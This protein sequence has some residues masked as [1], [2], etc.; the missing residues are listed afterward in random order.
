MTVMTATLERPLD[1]PRV[2]AHD[3]PSVA[4]LAPPHRRSRA[5]RR[6]VLLALAVLVAATT[7]SYVG[8]LRAPGSGSV[9]ERSVEWVR[10]H[11][12][13][14]IVNRVEQW[15]Y[16]RKAPGDGTPTAAHLPAVP[17]PVDARGATVVEPVGR[18]APGPIASFAPDP[19]P[20]EGVWTPAIQQVGSTPVMYTTFV[21]PDPANTK[22]VAAI[23]RF[24]QR[25]VRT[26]AVPGTREPGGA[27]WAWQSQIPTSARV[28]LVAAFNSGFRFKHIDGGYYTEGRTSV[29]LVDGDA[30]LVIDDSGRVDIGTWGTDVSM[31]PTTATVRQN[32]H[33]I[34]ADGRP[35][36]G[37]QHNAD[38]RW[39]SPRH[40]LQIT[41]RSGVGVTADG[42]LVVVAG[43]HLTLTA[44]ANA[45]TSAGAV[46]GMQLDIHTR[47]VTVNL[48]QPVAGTATAVTATEL[49]PD[50]PTSP[51]RFL[52]V[53][54]RD[55]FA[56][57]VR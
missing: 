49:L 13:D 50:M 3:V 5:V 18:P 36:P 57:F 41:W 27:A 51:T 34:V 52:G 55:F 32:L 30:S 4:P 9:G 42:D 35:V 15:Y 14:G 16:T 39:G 26:V 28:G 7:V 22:V 54:H 43:D 2:A 31:T 6:L 21:R 8:Y 38:G 25:L 17:A 46:R 47:Q 33:L 10:D 48:F 40:Q 44:L 29:P 1:D 37:L 56:V 12:G 20:G 53:D 24:D 23:A 45:L 11:G 19:M